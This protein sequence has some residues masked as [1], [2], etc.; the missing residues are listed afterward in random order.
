[1]D[2][3]ERATL[4]TLACGEEWIGLD[5]ATRLERINHVISENKYHDVLELVDAKEDGQV[6]LHLLQDLSADRR[7][8]LLLDFEGVL[9][10]EIDQ[11]LN[12]WLEPLKDR[13]ALRKM[14]GIEVKKS[15]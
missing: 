4:P 15:G 8:T 6:I 10:A 12:V 11:G 14:R 1:M 9:K 13:S 7:G 2:L 3:Y 5:Q